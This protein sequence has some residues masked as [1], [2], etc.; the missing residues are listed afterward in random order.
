MAHPYA[1]KP[2]YCFWRR[3]ISPLE[4][5]QVDPVVRGKFRV[6]P[7]DRVAT[8]GSCFAQHIARHL[9]QAGFNYFV[10]ETLN[11]F[12][13]D[14]LAGEYNYGVF[15]ARYGNLYT[16]RQFSQLL[17]R[18]YGLF[19]PVDDIWSGPDGHFYD[20]YR[21]Q[22]QPGGF[23]SEREFW[24]D[25]DQ[26]LAAVRRAIED[27]D[28]F[29]FTLGLTEAWVNRKDGAVYPLCPGTAAGT[30]DPAQH[31][32]VNFRMTE[33]LTDM[34]EALDFIRARNPD[35]RFI[36]TVSPVALLATAEDRHVLVS[37]THSKSVLRTVCGELEAD[38]DDVAYFPSYEIITG[39]FSRGAYFAR[40]MREVTEAGVRH[41]MRLFM[42]HYADTQA[43]ANATQPEQRSTSQTEAAHAM[44]RSI[45][46]VVKVICDEEALDR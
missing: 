16:T 42:K 44:V 18:A 7:T 38:N 25:R 26:H 15:S 29:V 21:P 12:I 13:P 9:A 39:S 34:R 22:I 17:K 27:C 8:A 20:P 32:F 33:V 24:A 31:E 23:V 28:V 40:D 43:A 5:D 4:M 11:P 19:K 6:R 37:T 35:V 2:D 45:D 10:T 14:H 46:E 30:F 41:V 36:V 3:A 1:N